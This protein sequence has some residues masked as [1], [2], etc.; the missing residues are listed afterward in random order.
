MKH[1]IIAINLS[2]LGIFVAVVGLLR[3]GYLHAAVGA[4]LW[5]I[6]GNLVGPDEFVWGD[7]TEGFQMTVALD[8]NP[9]RVIGWIR[10]ATT[11]PRPYNAS[12][13]IY[14]DGLH[15][16]VAGADGVRVSGLDGRDDHTLQPHGMMPNHAWHWWSRKQ[17]PYGA[18]SNFGGIAATNHSV[19]ASADKRRMEQLLR[20]GWSPWDR[21]S[22][23]TV[24][25]LLRWQDWP[26][27]VFEESR[28]KMRITQPFYD[29]SGEPDQ[30]QPIHGFK[31]S[32]PPIEVDSDLTR[33]SVME[34][35][36]AGGGTS[37]TPQSK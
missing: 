23:A 32:S 7:V 27:W 12:L 25:R 9:L 17:H 10:N 6:C 34:S 28:V 2:V 3:P 36:A 20:V 18:W 13:L 21:T 35:L 26:H 33:R 8:E 14:G 24:F 31:V 37:G 5:V 15:L 16:E 11:E 30:R 22:A 19:S 29:R 1:L 4:R